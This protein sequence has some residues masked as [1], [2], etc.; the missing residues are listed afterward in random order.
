MRLFLYFE[1]KQKLGVILVCYSVKLTKYFFQQLYLQ[2]IIIK[3]D[4]I[5]AISLA[6]LQGL[7]EFLPIS[8][9][10]HLILLPIL[11]G[12]EDQGLAFDVAVHLGTLTAVVVY[13]RKDISKIITEWIGSFVGK[14]ATDDSKL[15][16]YVILGTIPVGLVGISMPDVVETTLRFPLVIATSTIVF[17]LLL[18]YS[19]RQAIETRSTVTLKIAI[20]I[21]L[22]QALA[23]I[24]GTSRSGITITAGLLMG[25]KRNYAARFSFL[26]SIPVIALAG[27][28]KGID[29]YKESE[30]V[31]WDM[32]IVGAVL[33][34]IVAY[35]SI[36]WFL[37]LLDKIG[38]MPFVYY[39][40]AL[41]IFLAVVF[42][43][44]LQ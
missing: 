21:G 38:M 29:L 1:D 4:I 35:I 31:M 6:V 33:S 9:S 40:I 24:P 11:L 27:M 42:F 26:L 39:R 41:G 15:A 32:M 5:Q 34:A 18:W 2:N 17:A 22:F 14:E 3:M 19:E 36:G 16:W 12:W 10:A 20:I 23:L 13:Y 37:K 8:S 28:L 44:Q 25:L 7:T 43:G 30:P